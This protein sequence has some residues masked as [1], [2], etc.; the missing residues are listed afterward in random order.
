MAKNKSKNK[1]KGQKPVIS[2][3]RFMREK[4]R[5]LPIGKCYITP[6]D[7]KESGMPTVTVTRV[8]PNGNLV[9]ASF[10]VDTFCLGVKDA[11]YNEKMTPYDFEN[12]LDRFKQKMGLEEISYNEAHNLIYGAMAFA[13]EGG[14]KPAKEFDPAGY[15]LEEDTDDIPLIEFDFGK[16][17]KHYLVVSPDEREML[18]CNVLKKNLG[19]N[20]EYIMPYNEYDDVY[21][22]YD[23]EYG[24]DDEDEDDDTEDSFSEFNP[25]VLNKIYEGLDKWI[26]ANERYPREIYTYQYPEYPESL[27]VKNQFIADELLSPDNCN[28]LPREVINRI[29]ALPK[30]EAARDISNIIF[31]SI[32]KT[33]KDINDNTIESWNNCAVMHSLILLVQLQSDKGLE[34]VLEIMRQTYD[35]V[36]YH[37]GYMFISLT[38]PALYAC[39]KDHI[40]AIEEYLNQPGLDSYLR[41]QATDALAMIVIYHPERRSEIIEAFRRILNNLILNLPDRK[42]CDGTFA[43]FVMSNL[44]DINAK[45]LITEIKDTFATDCVNKTICGDCNS[46]IKG[47]ED[48]KY[49]FKE[50]RYQIPD[51][52]EQYESL[53]ESYY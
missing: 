45:E 10:L 3:Y 35:F 11:M 34:A 13:E 33:Y 24:D 21:N 20:F 6:P 9:V 52:Y 48:G 47:I 44:I 51:I 7:W 12:Y 26:E 17:G 22:E 40:E 1:S 23:D 27:S 28:S 49:E 8:R 41:S 53:K 42:A 38:H 16:N 32:G 36:D 29:L 39:G 46:V 25:E 19:D 37:I 2:P 43:A 30:D 5:T 14:V 15:I 50:S 31:Y 18:Y 4:A